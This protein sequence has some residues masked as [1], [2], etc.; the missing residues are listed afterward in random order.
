MAARLEAHGRDARADHKSMGGSVFVA[1]CLDGLV[2]S[3]SMWFD[4][5]LVLDAGRLQRP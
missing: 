5:D 4:D 3:P 1:S 2:K